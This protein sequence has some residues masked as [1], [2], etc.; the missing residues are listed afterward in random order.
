V[1]RMLLLMI[2]WYVS[3]GGRAT[4]GL[5]L[6]FGTSPGCVPGYLGWNDG[7]ATGLAKIPL[8]DWMR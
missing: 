6:A 3:E 2:L 4:R 5:G 8:V 7:A 1:M